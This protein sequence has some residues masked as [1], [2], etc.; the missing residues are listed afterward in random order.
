MH[1]SLIENMLSRELIHAL[2]RMLIH[3]LWQGLLLAILAGVVVVSTRKAKAAV[4]YNLLT[5][6]FFGFVFLAGYTFVDA[7]NHYNAEPVN[8]PA[9]IAVA[10]SST[11]VF[12]AQNSVSAAGVVSKLPEKGITTRLSDFFN[13][14]TDLLVAIWFIIFSFKFIQT[15]LHIGYIYRV[16]N[17]RVYEPS[18]CWKQLLVQLSSALHINREI[19]LLQSELVK[20]PVVTGMLKPI[21]LIPASLLTKLDEEQIKAIILHELAHIKRKDYFVNI[22]QSF[23]QIIFFFNPAVLWVSSLIRDERENCCDDIAIAETK[24][25]KK[26]LEALVSFQEYNMGWAS[27]ATAFPGRKSHLLNRV[28]R[29]VYNHNKTLN[30]MEKIF[31][32]GSILALTITFSAIGKGQN[33]TT[34]HTATMKADTTIF[35]YKNYYRADISEG[36][37]LKLDQDNLHSCCIV[38]REGVVYQVN[39]KSGKLESYWID[40][41]PV[42][43]DKA[44]SYRPFVDKLVA[45]YYGKNGSTGSTASGIEAQAEL[46]AEADV[47]KEVSQHISTSDPILPITKRPDTLN[48]GSIILDKGSIRYFSNGYEVVTATGDNKVKAIYYAGERMIGDKFKHYETLANQIVNEQQSLY[49]KK[50]QSEAK[51]LGTKIDYDKVWTPPMPDPAPRPTPTPTPGKE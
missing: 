26:F 38:K 30:N 46:Q 28:K 7:F 27:Y 41:K 5:S 12:P 22:L 15:V 23:A 9:A 39:V 34:T 14:N 37:T 43:A 49:M 21:I 6:L 40:G 42:T 45:Q 2:S 51:R 50:L 47:M 17:S 33:N 11:P 32:T 19:R 48:G 18:P 29:I 36:S 10:E 24:S 4:R 13:R 1:Y 8:Q 44:A 35:P 20:V 25:K 3:S 16:R 31:L